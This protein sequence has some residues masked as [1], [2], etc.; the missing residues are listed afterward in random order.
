MIEGREITHTVNIKPPMDVL[1]LAAQCEARSRQMIISGL[2]YHHSAKQLP[3][4]TKLKLHAMNL[5][6]L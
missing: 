4:D 6:A 1:N 3:S 5:T 2:V